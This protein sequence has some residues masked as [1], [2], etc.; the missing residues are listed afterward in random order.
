MAI[1]FTVA[2]MVNVLYSVVDRAFIGRIDNVG[3][4]ALSGLGI[5]FPVIV[6][7]NACAAL[8]GAG[9][10]P[11]ASIKWGAKNKE[12][13][14]ELMGTSFSLLIIL[15]I[16]L[17]AGC[18]IIKA[19]LLTAFGATEDNLPFAIEYLNVYL[20]GTLFIM[21]SL[22]MN[23]FI[24]SQGFAKMGMLTTLIGAVINVILDPI[25]IF[26]FNMGIK[27]AALASVLAQFVSA[28]WVVLFLISKKPY[29]R[30]KLQYLKISY[31]HCKEILK[32]GVSSASF[33]INESLVAIVLNL[34]LAK[35]GGE[36]AY[37]YIAA[38]AIV[39]STMQIFFMPLTGIVRAAQPIIGFNMGQRNIARIKETISITRKCCLVYSCLFWVLM[40]CASWQIAC[41]FTPDP[42]LR[43][44]T[45][46]A[47]KYTY[48]TIFVI[49]MQMANQHTF[50]SMGNAKLSFFFGIL[51][52][53]LL[54]LPCAVVLPYFMGINGVFLSEAIANVIAVIITYIVFTKYISQVEKEFQSEN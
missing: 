42:V 19:P 50:V 49:G 30:I 48:C 13:T 38:L 18:Y 1:P 32:L 52:K 46:T 20:M 37:I 36:Q 39:N 14:H 33:H 35:W 44:I 29:W 4:M 22:G 15:G 45:A 40:M 2:Q 41:I 31:K 16:I 54:L 25:F 17:T 23:Q 27:G 34:I 9:G 6:L 24:S 5:T 28:V 3:T 10:A 12:E 8:I 51:R 11:L 7:I 26:V 21:I 53:V 43:T 47:L